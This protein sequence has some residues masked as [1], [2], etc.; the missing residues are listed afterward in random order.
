MEDHYALDADPA[1]NP[2]QPPHDQQAK[3][4]SG[5]RREVIHQAWEAAAKEN[6]VKEAEQK[7]PQGSG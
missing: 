7:P 5:T 2:H 4:H 3:H 1:D 6:K